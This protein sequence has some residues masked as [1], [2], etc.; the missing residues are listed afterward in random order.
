[1][2]KAFSVLLLVL[3]F[4]MHVKDIGPQKPNRSTDKNLPSW[5]KK[6]GVR[7]EPK[8]KKGFSVNSFGAKPDGATDST[9]AIQ[10]AIDDCSKSGGGIVSFE[11]G[12]Y[13]TGAIF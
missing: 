7:S 5:T 10:Q 12:E 13:V 2:K 6:A 11:K 1:M 8:G 3:F 4:A 9:K